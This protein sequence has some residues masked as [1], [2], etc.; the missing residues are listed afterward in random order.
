MKTTSM[1]M[2]LSLVV[3]CGI[4][5]RNIIKK[6]NTN[7][8]TITDKS[9]L[10]LADSSSAVDGMFFGQLE[11]SAVNYL[12]DEGLAV[13]YTFGI[14]VPEIRNG[15]AT[16]QTGLL[17]PSSTTS[18]NFCGADNDAKAGTFTMSGVPIYQQKWTEDTFSMDFVIADF[19]NIGV[20]KN[21]NAY[22]QGGENVR[23]WSADNNESVKN[24][25]KQKIADAEGSVSILYARSDWFPQ[26]LTIVKNYSGIESISIPLN[27]EQTKILT[28]VLSAINI[29]KDLRDVGWSGEGSDMSAWRTTIDLVPMDEIKRFDTKELRLPSAEAEKVKAQRI[30]YLAEFNAKVESAAKRNQEIE[31]YKAEIKDLPPM[32]LCKEWSADAHEFNTGDYCMK[33]EETEICPEDRSI[34]G[35]IYHW[36]DRWTK[37]CKLTI[38]SAGLSL[39]SPVES[40]E[41]KLEQADFVISFDFSS[42]LNTE[43]KVEES[44]KYNRVNGVPFNTQ[45]QIK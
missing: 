40:P 17:R 26:P 9:G 44:I 6:K 7:K 35:N 34:D 10:S 5:D 20:I 12:K 19:R 25:P 45:V 2:I 16:C 43:V 15:K 4:E 27:E 41:Q 24:L 3:G 23:N 37:Y 18:V 13:Q 14:A 39:A 22:V 29:G 36:E 21:G 30:A 42:I 38:T 28:E 33:Y 31:A 8:L 1:V 11:F 32:G